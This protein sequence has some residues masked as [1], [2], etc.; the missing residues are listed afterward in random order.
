[1]KEQK[2]I[3]WFNELEIEDIPYVGGKNASLGEMYRNLSKQKVSVP[4]GF[5]IT[6]HAYRYLLESTGAREKIKKIFRGLNTRNIRNLQTKG[7]QVR[8]VVRN[9]EFPDILVKEISK[10]YAKMEKQYGKD[11]AVAVRSSAT[12]EDLPD[13][14][15]AGQ[16]ETYL[17]I[18]GEEDLIDACK[19]CFASLFTNRAISYRVDKGFDHFSI[20]LS[21]GVQRMVKSAAAGVM[22][23][24]DTETGFQDAV[25]ITGAY[26]LGETVVQGAVNP[27]EFYVHKPTLEKGFK[28][29]I[30]KTLG[31]KKIKMIYS[32]EKS[33][34]K[35]VI[36]PDADRRKFVLSDKEILLLAKWAIIIEDHYSHKKNRFTPM[37]IE[38]AKDDSGKLFIVQA[39]PET[40]A[41][42]KDA[43]KLEEFKLSRKG[44]LLI[45]GKSV[46]ARIGSG[47]VRVIKDAKEIHKFRKGEV[48]ITDMTDP[49]WEPI[50]KI[51]SAIVTNRGGRTCFTGDTKVLTSEG[52]LT[53]EQIHEG[54]EGLKVPSL[55]R[56]TLK[57]EWKPVVASMK[58]QSPAIEINSSQTGRMK[59]NT[60]RLTPDHNMTTYSGNKLVKKQIKDI[61]SDDDMLLV[62][63]NLPAL[64]ASSLKERD[65]AYLVGAI[66]TD[67]HIY[68]N[69]NH[70]E[71]TFIQKPTQSKQHFISHVNTCMENVFSKSFKETR[72]STSKG[73]IR[74]KQVIGN[75]NAYRCYSKLI[76]RELNL[77]METF[78]ETLLHADIQLCYSFLAGVIDGDGSYCN[79]RINI[80]ISKDELLQQVIV[81]LLRVG[82]VPQVTTNRNISNVQIVEKVNELFVY[83]KRVKGDFKERD[84][85]FF[86]SKQLF[87][88]DVKGQLKLRKEKNLLISGK[89]LGEEFDKIKNSDTRMIRTSFERNMGIQDVFNI[90]VEDNHNYLVFTDRYTPIIV[91]NCHAAIISRELGIPCVVGTN[92]V[93]EVVKTGSVTV[94]CSQGEEGKVYAGKIG[95]RVRRIDI[96]KIPKTKTMIMMNLAN[97]DEAFAKSF[98]PNDGVGLA[99][100]EFIINSFIRIHPKALIHYDRLKDQDAKAQIADLTHGYKDKKQYFVEKL[101]QGVGMIAAAFYPKD[102]IVRM[103]DFKS[104]EY[105]KLIGG[106]EFE[107]KEDNPMIGWRGASRYYTD[108]ADAFRL[109]CKAMRKVREEFGLTNVKLMIPF[110]RT[111]EEGKKVLKVMARE[112]LK[113]GKKGLQ[114]Y[115]MCEI[116]SNV[117]LAEEF[118]DIFDG[119]SIGSNDLTQLLLGVDRDSS[120]VAPIADERNPAVMKM[121]SQVIKVCKKRHIK[122]GICGDGPSTFPEFAEFLVKEGI[123]S[124]SLTSDVILKTRINVAKVEKR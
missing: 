114:V 28:P 54:F 83:T 82:I 98:I 119:F 99:R 103:S 91:E 117:I 4:N 108:Y 120:L 65:L 76:A 71:V 24:I 25:F 105:A 116:P 35:T 22:F 61:L 93:T 107:P 36:V 89:A 86:S 59:G 110:C 38:W 11:A 52:F 32:D 21:I 56:E 34:T 77:E 122:I 8:N 102:V 29:I 101:A 118:A 17:N 7:R 96:K 112:G 46:G 85:Q 26:G 50:M 6:A 115:V 124:L 66:S 31:E 19:R 5:A 45:V 64:T 73:F 87:P 40:V 12:A 97:P 9:L 51:A 78:V 67:G 84:T 23:S 81:A 106:A 72:K 68:T 48:L 57:I 18:R 14:S 104:N 42:Q 79:N 70:G 111:V 20:A 121:I 94:D 41:S 100:E 30:K 33:P 3:L 109:E 15:F 58:K 123:D 10:A 62:A 53:M 37:D 80:Y 49:D 43:S 113:R 74:G 39:R 63:Q 2:F 1:M 60:L 90:T 69:K 44:K 13:A 16:Q 27:D 47:K 92:T 88:E 55:N 75:A 95:Y